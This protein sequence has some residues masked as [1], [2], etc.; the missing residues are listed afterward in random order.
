MRVLEARFHPQQEA[1]ADW[2]VVGYIIWPDEIR[3]EQPIVGLVPSPSTAWKGM[4]A[5]KLRYLVEAT[6]PESFDR[7]QSLRSRFWSFV[8]VTPP[9]TARAH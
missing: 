1:N 2:V 5:S 6:T 8:E 9:L 7:L 4:I 3:G